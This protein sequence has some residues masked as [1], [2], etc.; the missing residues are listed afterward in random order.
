LTGD[1]HR[2]LLVPM[3]FGH[4]FLALSE[5][6]DLEYKCSGYYDRSAEGTVAWNDPEIGVEWP[7]PNPL[8]SPKDAQGMTLAEYRTHPAFI[9]PVTR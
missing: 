4:A 1:N 5:V 2:Q 8:V 9:Y 7:I 6:A 3:G